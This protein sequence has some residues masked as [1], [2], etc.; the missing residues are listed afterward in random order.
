MPDTE[1]RIIFP[2][3]NE[4]WAVFNRQNQEEY[5]REHGPDSHDCPGDAPCY[6]DPECEFAIC[7]CCGAPNGQCVCDVLYNQAH[8]K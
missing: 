6:E 1:T 3:T 8:D 4:E 7:D 5:E 2:K